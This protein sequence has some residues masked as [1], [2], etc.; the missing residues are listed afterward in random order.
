MK[1]YGGW[2]LWW[3]Y[4]AR[5]IY[6]SFILL[7]ETI[8]TFLTKYIQLSYLPCIKYFGLPVSVSCPVDGNV[9]EEERLPLALVSKGNTSL[10]L[11]LK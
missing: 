10:L 7:D 6:F 8:N 3:P 5:V 11:S 1:W 2:K 9:I 4:N